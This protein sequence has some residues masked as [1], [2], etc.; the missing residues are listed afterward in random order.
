LNFRK[1]QS[2]KDREETEKGVTNIRQI[3]TNLRKRERRVRR[4]AF[5][6]RDGRR[7][8]EGGRKRELEPERG[9]KFEMAREVDRESW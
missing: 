9:R 6:R 2:K 8:R 5:R 7:K 4:K 1:R 3:T